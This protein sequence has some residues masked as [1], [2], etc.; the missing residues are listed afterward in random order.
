MFAGVRLPF[1]PYA[2]KLIGRLERARL[3]SPNGVL[4]TG[5][6]QRPTGQLLLWVSAPC[7]CSSADRAHCKGN[8]P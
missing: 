1:L 8:S 2:A 5:N 3:Q 6:P 4:V 7:P